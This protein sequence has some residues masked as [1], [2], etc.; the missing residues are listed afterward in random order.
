MARE[1]SITQEQ[2]S[3]IADSIKA[4][5]DK[6][7]NRNVRERLGSG[8]PGTVL[9][10]MQVWKLGQVKS[11]TVEPAL[12][13]SIIVA[14]NNQ[15]AKRVKDETDVMTET[16]E[17]LRVDT[18]DIIADNER[19]AAEIEA[20][21]ANAAVEAER[22]ALQSGRIQQLETE[23]ARSEMVI[24]DLRKSV[25][26]AKMQLAK[27]EFR[28]EAVPHIESDLAE[29]RACLEAERINSAQQHEAAA[30]ALARLEAIEKHAARLTDQLVLANKATDEASKRASAAAEQ[31]GD[32]KVLIITL[33]SKLE[34]ITPKQTFNEGVASIVKSEQAKKR[35]R[36][37]KTK[38]V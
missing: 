38:L 10:F 17:E 19:K 9:K 33:Q 36:P 4:S 6:P 14:I 7:T 30:V 2:V 21:I 31:L 34:A 1:A 5:G 8:S 22:Y 15:I 35:G 29:A 3:G 25:E 24:A 11:Q 23:S 16:L 37:A 32:A 26:V 28:L 18:G 13:P 27:S 12:D 20:A